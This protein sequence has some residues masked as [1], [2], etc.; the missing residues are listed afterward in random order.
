MPPY[1]FPLRC[2]FSL[3]VNFGKKKMKLDWESLLDDRDGKYYWGN[4]AWENCLGPK[5]NLGDFSNRY[6]KSASR[7]YS[8]ALSRTHLCVPAVLDE[9]EKLDTLRK[10]GLV[11]DN[12]NN[13]D[14]G[15]VMG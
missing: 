9:F 8:V 11:P 10:H 15:S 5:R 7:D 6:Y 12:M 1:S 2:A 13:L 3:L 4:L 14:C